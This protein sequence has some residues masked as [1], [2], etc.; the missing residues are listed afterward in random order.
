MT[1]RKTYFEY[2]V[3]WKGHPIEDASGKMKLI[4]R[5]M[6]SQCRSSWTWVHEFLSRGVW[7]RSIVS[8]HTWRDNSMP[9]RTFE[10][11]QNINRWHFLQIF[12]LNDQNNKCWEQECEEQGVHKEISFEEITKPRFRQRFWVHKGCVRIKIRLDS[13]Q[14]STE[15]RKSVEGCEVTAEIRSGEWDHPS[16]WETL[17]NC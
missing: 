7:C 15:R 9:L 14:E 5:S 4:S 3:K 16:L 12:F 1:R 11:F 13:G 8:K 2:L 10:S 6:E 17:R